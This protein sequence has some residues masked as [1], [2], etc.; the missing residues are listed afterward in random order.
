MTDNPSGIQNFDLSDS[1]RHAIEEAVASWID[2]LLDGE[3]LDPLEVLSQHPGIGHE[4]IDRLES[5]VNLNQGHDIQLE[6]L[7][8]F[9]ILKRLGRGGMGV[10]YKAQQ[11]SMNREV[12]LKILP[13][14]V[15]ADQTA[16]TRFLREAQAA[17]RIHH[18]AVVGVH[19][20]GIEAE[21][22]YYAMEYVEGE[23]LAAVNSSRK[24]K[25]PISGV[26]FFGVQPDPATYFVEVAKAFSSLAE[27]LHHAHREGVIHRDIKPSNIMVDGEGKLRILDF[28]L[29]YFGTHGTLTLTGEVVGTPLYMSPEQAKREKI[30]VDHRTDIYS[31][32]AT[33]YEVLTLEA[34]YKGRDRHDILRKILETDP[35]NLRFY[36]THI[37]RDLETI[38][39]KCMRRNP[40]G[41]YNSAQAMAQDL[42][43]FVN[44]EPI[45]AK[46][47]G[48]W[49]KTG[50]QILRYRTKIMVTT[51]LI[52]S[53]FMV[54]W[55]SL[56]VFKS[57]R[58]R[59][60]AEYPG[61]LKEVVGKLKSS[62]W[63]L[64]KAPSPI[65]VPGIGFRVFQPGD[66]Q[67]VVK[68]GGEDIVRS[69]LA[70]LEELHRKCPQ[71]PEAV[72]HMAKA[73]LA[74]GDKEKAISE[75]KRTL[76]LDEKFLAA[77]VLLKN[78]DRESRAKKDLEENPT[79]YKDSW[80]QLWNKA[81]YLERKRQNQ[82]AEEV[83]T[84]L[85]KRFDSS[86]PPYTGFLIN[87]YLKRAA[88]R[89]NQKKFDLAEEDCVIARGMNADLPISELMLGGAYLKA[90]KPELA[91]NTFKRLRE[92]F[93]DLDVVPFWIA[94][95]YLSD[96]DC[97]LSEAL[98]WA[99]TVQN[100]A[101]RERLV[102]YLNLRLSNWD[103]A[104][105]ASQNLIEFDKS[106]LIS[107]Q[108]LAS[109]LIKKIDHS[110][111]PSGIQINQLASTC[112]DLMK[113]QSENRRSRYLL[114][115][116][117][118]LLRK[119]KLKS[120]SKL[121][122]AEDVFKQ[123]AQKAWIKLP[124]YSSEIRVID[125]F[126]R[127]PKL[128]EDAPLTWNTIDECC[129]G[130]M[131]FSPQGLRLTKL[132]S[133]RSWDAWM[134][135]DEVF[136]G[137]VSLELSGE[138]GND[139]LYAHLHV[140]VGTSSLYY[141]GIESR[142]YLHIGKWEHGRLVMR[143]TKEIEMSLQSK[144][145]LQLES[146]G[147]TVELRVWPEDGVKPQEPSLSLVD[148]SLRLGAIGIGTGSHPATISQVKV[149]SK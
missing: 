136:S 11:E 39:L 30:Q 111:G 125:D 118:E 20:L 91:R 53:V 133:E 106:Q 63:I 119:E 27:G 77:V 35:P 123:A 16:F 87:C 36:K 146:R 145:H 50:R 45:E 70:E 75:L 48:H 67:D 99:E 2:R 147:D 100:N 85:I 5:F 62:A 23:T 65:D 34:P 95:V 124:V 51:A 31:L 117:W 101:H 73:H 41:R 44:G 18:P 141:G 19:S 104:I 143:E 129:P 127:D 66:F 93:P 142:G 130:K 61:K 134:V 103:K 112:L 9:K 8:D 21:T 56:A 140:E 40:N 121:D 64:R 71:E 60:L 122:W 55:L 4:I 97:D 7:G 68:F 54:A 58:D 72:Y 105:E 110:S 26:G 29:A 79:D 22:P 59:N 47:E 74:L 128:R 76:A 38:V 108:L 86:P 144:V 132:N 3:K 32:G 83:F 137:D 135:S 102:T 80:L 92:R 17:G 46:P 14:P 107:H 69:A 138:V 113:I 82:Q 148:S 42:E 6:R 88:V 120:D 89:L 126:T 15:A 33:L 84:Q 12:A 94:K 13:A 116:G 10:V 96:R 43:R 90:D 115:S 1:S 24:S 98:T 37:P 78:L 57:E 49:V 52:L 109:S 25:K 131:E 139:N 28:G 149:R 114:F 81:E